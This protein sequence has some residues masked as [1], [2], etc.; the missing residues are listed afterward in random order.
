MIRK[1][2]L[3]LLAALLVLLPVSAAFG[4]EAHAA[5]SSRIAV[6]KQLSGDVQVQK[7]GGS[8]QFKAFAKLSLN[9]GDKLITG[10]KGSAVLQFA[11]GTSED[12]K[13][14]VG[15]NATL[16]FSKLSDK[17]G[18]VTKVS[19]L[20][21]TAWVDVKSIKS[22]DDD[23]KLETPTAIMGVRGTAFFARVNPAT[24]GTNT[25]VMSGVVRFTSE[26]AEKTGSG[27]GESTGGAGT[28][29]AKTI[30]LYPTQQISLEPTSGVDL[31]ELTTL[32]DIEDIVKNASPE[33]IE[34][35]LR[36][37]AKVD[38]ENRQTVE[39]FKQTG[40]P[41]DLQQQLEQFIQNTQELLGV[42]AKQA[43]EQKKLDE[44]QV[45]KI[46]EQEK[47]SFGLDKDQLSQLSDK[48]KAKQEKAR[49]LAEEAA[50]KKA[51]EEAAKLKELAD[52]INASA[53][54]AIEAAKQAQAQANRLAAEAAKR[55]AEEELLKKLNEQQKQQYQQDKANHQGGTPVTPGTNTNNLSSNANLGSLS[56]AGA[57]LSPSFDAAVTAYRASV[58]SDKTSVVV[59]ASV[60]GSGASFTVN[61]QAPSGGQ[62]TVSLAYGDNEI[63]IL[64]M[65]QNGSTQAY[66]VTVT[67][68]LLNNVSVVFAGQSGIDIDFN[69]TN[70]PEP[71]SIPSGLSNL[72]LVV[73]VTG[74]EIDITVNGQKV[75]PEPMFM[76]ARTIQPG[77]IS[78]RYIIPLAQA[79]NEI[80]IKATIDGVVKIYKLIANRAPETGMP[81][82]YNAYYEA[83]YQTPYSGVLT[84]SGG[85]GAKYEL[86][87][88]GGPRSGTLELGED[89][90]FTYMPNEGFQ[91]VDYFTFKAIV[92]AKESE[93]AVVTI[94]V[95][96]YNYETIGLT[97]WTSSWNG[98]AVDDWLFIYSDREGESVY[99]DYNLYREQPS[100]LRLSFEFDPLA[101][102]DAQLT[103]GE[104]TEDQDEDGKLE[105]DLAL[106]AGIN[107]VSLRYSVGNDGERT[108]YRLSFDVYVGMPSDSGIIA[109]QKP[110]GMAEIDLVPAGEQE[111]TASVRGGASGADEQKDEYNW[112]LINYSRVEATTVEV[113]A[114]G[115]LVE[116]GIYYRVFLKAGWNE[117]V[118][119]SY[120]PGGE[121]DA[122]EQKIHVWRGRNAPEGYAVTGIS[123]TVVKVAPEASPVPVSFIRDENR[124]DVWRAAVTTDTTALKIRP[125][126]AAGL[127]L[128]DFYLK[129]DYGNYVNAEETEPGSGRFIVPTSEAFADAY[130]VVKPASGGNPFPYRIQIAKG[131]PPELG[132]VLGSYTSGSS[133]TPGML[134]FSDAAGAWWAR[135]ASGSDPHGFKLKI[136]GSPGY[137]LF[138][139]GELVPNAYQVSVGGY[140]FTFDPV[141]GNQVYTLEFRDLYGRIVIY[142]INLYYGEVQDNLTVG[143]GA[144]ITYGAGNIQLLHPTADSLSATLPAGMK[145]F[146]LDLD[147]GEHAAAAVFDETG[148]EM[149]ASGDP[150]AFTLPDTDPER[151]TILTY[152]VVLTDT[153][154]ST[155]GNGDQVL[156]TLYLYMAQDHQL[157]PADVVW[158]T[159]ASE[160]GS[161]AEDYTWVYD[162]LNRYTLSVPE[163][164]DTLQVSVT[165][166]S[167]V[168]SVAITGLSGP[169]GYNGYYGSLSPGPNEFTM[170][171]SYTDGQRRVYELT[172]YR[173][174]P[175]S[176]T[177]QFG[178]QT[179]SFAYDEA[180][181]GYAV[182]LESDP[183]NGAFNLGLPNGT[184]VEEVKSEDAPLEQNADGT[185][186]LNLVGASGIKAIWASGG[187]NGVP[188]S[189]DFYVYY[190]TV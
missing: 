179:Y 74:P 10:S 149:Y 71:L 2:G 176:P 168:S 17:K 59:G 154:D 186:V 64:V 62:R 188:W 128:S 88:N 58:T 68:Q 96:P 136:M 38:E 110:E 159:Q 28:S 65:A 178:E 6:I 82:A 127:S 146:S 7:A 41:S 32:V 97:N 157:A 108:Y 141:P 91:G 132:F 53:L 183:G 73:P 174:A 140:V 39:K 36:S 162:R 177:L 137:R 3:T 45:K 116:L 180:L 112:L 19:M 93:P 130:A 63:T 173:G 27:S 124:A 56:I 34:A 21:G 125:N 106:K 52:K 70:A 189:S 158:S 30:D 94:R 57:T 105:A 46:E 184:E 4:G 117:I 18:T 142:P 122:L 134:P 15:E 187:D 92:G 109:Y 31:R 84:S 156:Y 1:Y 85:S 98:E 120:Y 20:K 148:Q 190:G 161:S 147:L 78:W 123:G 49:Q 16:T 99:K 172:A 12:D 166:G 55:K 76:A 171:V 23:F 118:I 135:L 33:V 14:T 77:Q 152:D 139:N 182:Y 185:F 104:Q 72:T 181:N 131:D 95:V 164:A 81:I 43:I 37:K 87:E 145:S 160:G 175:V 167:Y 83:A 114:N 29:G 60:Q 35:I 11:N 113:V 126:L 13:F 133:E 151:N 102:S 89:G 24:G 22:Q 170:T 47:T 42:I 100:T 165:P 5:S 155:S 101:V 8:K 169:D 144:T 25:A 9:Q 40:V 150:L 80:E 79:S 121:V 103:F 61:G 107:R 153:D 50:K 44:Q 51:A 163:N 129:D 138:A 69:S 119:R 26:K 143:N 75:D 111:W 86:M 67:R 54:K 48:E 66:R 90:R 115:E